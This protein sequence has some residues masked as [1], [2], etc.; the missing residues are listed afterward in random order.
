MPIL[1]FIFFALALGFTAFAGA[2]NL[3]KAEGEQKRLEVDKAKLNTEIKLLEQENAR[4]AKLVAEKLEVIK[5]LK[6][7]LAE[8]QK[9]RDELT[10]SV[11]AAEKGAID[12]DREQVTIEEELKTTRSELEK[13]T[14]KSSLATTEFEQKRDA[15]LSKKADLIAQKAM[16]KRR[17]EE[18]EAASKAAEEETA[19]LN[20]D[21]AKL[22]ET[23]KPKKQQ[24][25]K[26]RKPAAAPK[27]V[28]KSTGE[29][30]P[31]KA[32]RLW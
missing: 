30:T 28:E 16:L 6:A 31:R 19:R 17:T 14:V 11:K 7:E 32:E 24:P 10:A 27:E 22:S 25:G 29:F 1:K 18:F 4:Q 3:D 8:L 12:A 20:Q 15:M 9:Q 23:E 21:I 26:R 5:K 13:I 2:D